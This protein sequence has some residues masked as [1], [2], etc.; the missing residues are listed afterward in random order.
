MWDG[1]QSLY[2]KTIL[3]HAERGYG[4]AIQFCRYAP[5]V[6]AR[7]ARV[8]LEVPAPLR[9]L[10]SSLRGVTQIFAAGES[11]PAFDTHCP[12]M[13]LPHAFGTKL[14]TIPSATPYLRAPADAVSVWAQRL[15]ATKRPRIGIAWAG[16]PS[17]ENDRDRSIALRALL[18][19][20]E[21]DATFVSLQKELRA[22]DEAALQE[23]A[24]IVL[25]GGELRDFTD[26]AALV[27]NLDLVVT[28][29][30]SVAHLAGA[31][32]K[33]VWIL[34][35]FTPDWRW[36]IDRNTSRWYPSAR[37]F[38][39]TSPEGWNEVVARVKAALPDV[40][41]GAARG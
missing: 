31:L 10:M 41:G 22:G 33:P 9:Q 29:D 19:L 24:G 13:S 14:E 16:A 40:V 34:L 32:G 20:I 27:A 3:L 28:A 21:V 35:P 7:G 5:Q 37:L 39:Q 38:R 23:N 1:L 15:G 26:T 30:T 8:L 12:L 4:D 36:L 6:A 17:H 25:P 18:P 2:D 11:L